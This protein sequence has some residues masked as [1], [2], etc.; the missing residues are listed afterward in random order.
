MAQS[1][2]YWVA[3][4]GVEPAEAGV[5]SFHEFLKQFG[6]TLRLVEENSVRGMLDLFKMHMRNLARVRLPACQFA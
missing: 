1:A 4:C 5:T 3:V 6:K 2:F